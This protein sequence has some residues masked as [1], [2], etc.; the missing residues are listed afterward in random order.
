M[1]FRFLSLIIVDSGDSVHPCILAKDDAAR[2]H[3]Y[4]KAQTKFKTS[5]L[6]RLALLDMSDRPFIN[7]MCVHMRYVSKSSVK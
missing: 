6:R 7:S 2:M 4:T 3:E 1:I 5:N